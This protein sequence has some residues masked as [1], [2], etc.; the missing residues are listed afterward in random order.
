MDR[1]PTISHAESDGR[2]ELIRDLVTFQVKLGLDALRDFVFSPLSI[3]AAV[4]DLITGGQHPGRTFHAVLAAGERTESWI[5]LF[6]APNR[7]EGHELSAR[8][9]TVDSYIRQVEGLVVEQYERG[10]I[11]AS[12]KEAID[13]SLDKIARKGRP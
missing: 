12:A 3:A 5:N 4:L 9:P 1:L 11:T 10:G 7:T 8:G 13:R 6:G 2:W